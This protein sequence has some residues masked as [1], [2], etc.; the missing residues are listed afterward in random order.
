[1]WHPGKDR[2]RHNRYPLDMPGLLEV[3][4]D[5]TNLSV[6]VRVFEISLRGA[7][8]EL[9]SIRIESRHLIADHPRSLVLQLMLPQGMLLLPMSVR[10]FQH[11]PDRGVFHLGVRFE[12]PGPKDI[13][14]LRQF[15]DQHRF[16]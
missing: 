7:A 10:W 3:E 12:N 8:L 16:P 9:H 11:L 1:M 4:F 13:R 5:R 6:P 2:R 15:L 14:L